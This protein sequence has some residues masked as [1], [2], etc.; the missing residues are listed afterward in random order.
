MVITSDNQETQ[1]Y[2][3]GEAV[4]SDMLS[5]IPVIQAPAFLH[6]T[7]QQIINDPPLAFR[8]EILTKKQKQRNN[9]TVMCTLFVALFFLP[10]GQLTNTN[11]S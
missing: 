11:R 2:S 3:V 10:I 6:D 1:L 7:I 9:Q 4:V 8:F 5:E